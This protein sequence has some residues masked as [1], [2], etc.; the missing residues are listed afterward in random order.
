MINDTNPLSIAPSGRQGTLNLLNTG[1]NPVF[2]SDSA[3][4]MISAAY[5]INP[6]GNLQWSAKVPL[7]AFTAPNDTTTVLVNDAAVTLANTNVSLDGP[8][9]AVVDGTVDVTG[10]VNATILND[11]IVNRGPGVT[12]Y[13]EWLDAST[14]APPSAPTFLVDQY[15]SLEVSMRFNEDVPTFGFGQ[16]VILQFG[17][18]TGSIPLM[19]NE[20]FY[21]DTDSRVLVWSGP[22]TGRFA[23]FFFGYNY[24]HADAVRVTI[25]A[26]R[27]V[28]PGV[29]YREVG[30]PY[31][32]LPNLVEIADPQ[33][34]PV[35]GLFKSNIP[36]TTGAA[37]TTQRIP[38]IA[39]KRHRVYARRAGQP[40]NNSNHMWISPT[41]LGL[42]IA[43]AI[44]QSFAKETPGAAS[45]Y[46]IDFDY[47]PG[48][49]PHYLTFQTADASH[50]AV[51]YAITVER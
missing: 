39:G 34:D 27:S 20:T 15:S 50:A 1:T 16:C 40:A 6:N 18:G 11:V 51:Q 47:Y 9:D 43:N 46:N 28:V 32:F 29:S 42:G 33:T 5:Q 25:R 24:D 45:E 31:N 19:M 22:V 44:A 8:I 13:D 7:Y 30:T 14:T 36:A 12:L 4:G 48:C 21:W 26:F 38:T 23:A 3:S 49:M 37:V 41:P 10:S 17:T 35:S 2:V